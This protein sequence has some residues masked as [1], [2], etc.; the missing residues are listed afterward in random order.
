MRAGAAELYPDPDLSPEGL[1][2]RILDLVDDDARRTEMGERAAAWSTPDADE[3][4]AA[5]VEEAHAMT[6]YVRRRAASRRSPCPR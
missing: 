6:S 2:R 1:A 4:L 3:R 5:L